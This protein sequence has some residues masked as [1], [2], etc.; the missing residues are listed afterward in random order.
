MRLLLPVTAFLLGCQEYGYTEARFEEVFFQEDLESVADILLVIDDSPSM[1]EEQ[2]LL[3]QNFQAFVEVVEG[4]YADYRAGV[5]TTDVSTEAA[6]VLQGALITPDTEDLAQAFLD[7]VTVGATGSRDEQGLQAA[8]LALDGRNPGFVRADATLHVVVFSDE[9]D[10]SPQE[11][12]DHLAA[13]TRGAG[14]GRLVVHAIVGNLPQ[15]CASGIAAAD[16]GTRYIEAAGLTGGYH[17]SIC[18]EDYSE[19]LAR[20]GLD[21]SGLKDTFALGSLPQPDSLEVWVDEVRVPDRARDGWVYDSGQ[22]AIVFQG[23][24]V[25]RPGMEIVVYY[26]VLAGGGAPSDTGA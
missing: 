19:V 9:D 25:P 7:A 24:A 13:L 21:L 22:N 23:W 14:N 11:V 12:T 16:A 8:E 18:A 4:T 20:I 2:E 3:G 15:G 5:V 26:E 1:A 6:G 10:H 17:D